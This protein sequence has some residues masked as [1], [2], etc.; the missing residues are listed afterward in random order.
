MLRQ[1]YRW[2]SFGPPLTFY[3]EERLLH[4]EVHIL[5]EDAA[6]TGAK[7]RCMEGAA[8]VLEVLAHGHK[9]WIRTAP[10]AAV[11]TNFATGT[12]MMRG[13][14]RFI[15]SCDDGVWTWLDYST[16]PGPVR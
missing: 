4:V 3:P 8:K 9:A 1:T 14:V 11:Q 13:Y 2:K 7:S 12:K 16:A 6:A 15:V 5:A 10:E